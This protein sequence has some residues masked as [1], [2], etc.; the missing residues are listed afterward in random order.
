MPTSKIFAHWVV[1]KML[2]KC[3]IF[4]LNNQVLLQILKEVAIKYAKNDDDQD[5]EPSKTKEECD[6]GGWG[7]RSSW[8]IEP[9]M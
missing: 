5:R 7:E 4:T 9:L 3:W 8:W 2:D 1:I 6:S